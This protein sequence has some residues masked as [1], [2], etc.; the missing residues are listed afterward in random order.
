MNKLLITLCFLI[1]VSICL[2]QNT[3]FDR[4]YEFGTWTAGWSMV[5]LQ[6]TAF[7]VVGSND[8]LTAS[9][10]H[11]SAII[12]KFDLM[13]DLLKAD[14]YLTTD[15]DF[16]QLF[17]SNSDDQFKSIIKTPDNNLLAVGLTQSYGATNFFDLDI[18]LAKL[19][20][21][22]D[23]LWTKAISHPNDTAFRPNQIIN[24]SDGGYLICGWQ[25][26]F[27]SPNVRS[28]LCKVDSNGNV[29]WRTSYS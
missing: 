12:S 10:D 8:S 2:S 1:N 7:I 16:F 17:N 21:N 3:L 9:V 28:F 24:T 5:N 14:Q 11:Y 6:D 18:F 22:L 13:G 19:N 25:N 26:S 20:Y 4:H 23:T 29:L 15:S 27:V